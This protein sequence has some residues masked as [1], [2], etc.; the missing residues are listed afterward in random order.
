MDLILPRIA[1]ALQD[2]LQYVIGFN[3]FRA[4]KSRVL[5]L[6]AV[7][8]SCLNVLAAD[9][10]KKPVLL[11]TRYFTAP[12]D[13]RYSLDGNFKDVLSNL[14]TNFDVRVN[15]GPIT[16]NSLADVSV[17]LI[18]NP[19]EQKVGTN[20]PP[21][22]ISETV[23]VISRYVERGGGLIVMG[24]QEGHNVDEA[25]ANTLLGRFGLQLTNLYT[26]IKLLNV[27][28]NTPVIGGLRWGYFVG[29]L[30]LIETNHPAKPRTLVDND[31]A[32]PLGRFKRNQT[33]SLLAVAEPGKGRVVVATDCGWI[34]DEA[35]E[36]KA[37]D[38]MA[39]KD[40]DEWEIMRRLALWASGR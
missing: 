6:T 39:I 23:G 12:G 35:L 28:H 25:G 34:T 24:N 10:P 21:H 9:S 17:L 18:A 20:A 36:G 13:H 26:D 1:I 30:V 32:E 27:P 31:S 33:G 11:Y 22:P 37:I 16:E 14:K 38:G 19:D 2:W 5:L 4:M 40:D 15:D 3:R 29:D 7:L 8:F